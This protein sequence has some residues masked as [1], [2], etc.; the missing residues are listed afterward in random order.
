MRI[1]LRIF[2]GFIANGFVLVSQHS[3]IRGDFLFPLHN[4]RSHSIHLELQNPLHCLEMIF[5]FNSM[6]SLATFVVK[7]LES[8]N[9][10]VRSAFTSVFTFENSLQC[11]PLLLILFSFCKI[12]SVMKLCYFVKYFMENS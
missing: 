7:S 5:K 1:Y 12:Y 6:P 11:E 8:Q 9:L 4:L 10:S 3:S 2:V